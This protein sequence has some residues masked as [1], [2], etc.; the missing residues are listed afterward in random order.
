MEKITPVLT[1]FYQVIGIETL[2]QL[3]RKGLVLAPT[4]WGPDRNVSLRH[5]DTPVKNQWNGTCTSFATVAAVENKLGAEFELSER[6]LWDFYGQYSTPQAINAAQNN[7]ILEEKYWPQH[8]MRFD[9]RYRGK[10]RF[11]I[12][13]C[14]Y[15]DND[16]LRVL[17]AIDNGNPC[18]V[19]LQVPEALYNGDVQ[20]EANSRMLKGGHA[21]CVSGYKVENNKGYFLVKNSWG[22]SNGDQGYQ[23]I[24]FAVFDNKGYATFWEIKSVSD[25]GDQA[26][27][28]Q[29]TDKYLTSLADDNTLYV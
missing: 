10:G 13:K 18:V 3:Q 27:E 8:Q 1:N 16:Y 11:L 2:Q 9:T 25:R 6:S 15:L 23:Y 28:Y 19:A 24:D 22:T 29:D 26:L 5:R 17:T 4:N 20:V 14:E 12:V 21:I 7:H